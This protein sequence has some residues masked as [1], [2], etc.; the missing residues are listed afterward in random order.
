MQWAATNQST[1]YEQIRNIYIYNWFIES[2]CVVVFLNY[3]N[4]YSPR[5]LTTDLGDWQIS[6]W[7]KQMTN[8]WQ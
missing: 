1:K 3:R 2:R 7:C 5:K 6:P 4:Y 8:V